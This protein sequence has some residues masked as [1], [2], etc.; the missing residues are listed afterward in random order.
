MQNILTLVILDKKNIIKN[1]DLKNHK[2]NGPF[3]LWPSLLPPVCNPLWF[4]ADMPK[5]EEAELA[6]LE[7]ELEQEKAQLKDQGILIYNKNDRFLI[8]MGRFNFV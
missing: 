6:K 8:F 7:E 4:T 3:T 2:M 1:K 5:N